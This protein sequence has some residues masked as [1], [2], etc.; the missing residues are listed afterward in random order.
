MAVTQQVDVLRVREQLLHERQQQRV[1]GVLVRPADLAAPGGVLGLEVAVEVPQPVEPVLAREAVSLQQPPL[2]AHDGL[3]LLQEV[4]L[5]A[6]RDAGVGVEHQAQHRRPGARRPDDEDGRGRQRQ[7]GLAGSSVIG[8]RIP[9]PRPAERAPAGSPRVR[10]HP[11]RERAPAH[12]PPIVFGTDGWRARI[13]EDYTY[14]NVRRCAQGVAE[15]VQRAGDR[16]E[17]RRPRLRPAVLERVLRRGGRRGA[18]RLRHPGRHRA[19]G[20]S[21]PR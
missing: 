7:A 11:A 21:P 6:A 5:L 8:C 10:Y 19:R 16:R 3:H 9:A 20:R 12:Q 15:W 17:G 4:G 13:G 18:A 14:E 2:P 1:G